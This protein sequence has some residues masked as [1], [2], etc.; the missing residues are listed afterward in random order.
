MRSLK[1]SAL[2]FL[3]S[4][5]EAFVSPDLKAVPGDLLTLSFWEGTSENWVISDF[6][7]LKIQTEDRE[8]FEGYSKK[9]KVKKNQISKDPSD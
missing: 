5:G 1:K 8:N 4:E 7:R 9:Y 6:W 2:F 3:R